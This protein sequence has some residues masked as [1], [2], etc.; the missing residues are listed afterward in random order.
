MHSVKIEDEK[1]ALLFIDLDD[2]K[3]VND[4]AG[5]ETGDRVLTLVAE[6]LTTSVRSRDSVA[7][8]G[9]DEFA[10]ILNNCDKQ[11]ARIIAENLEAL[12]RAVEVDS[13]AGEMR[14]GV[15]I[16][17]SEIGPEGA[18]G[19]DEVIRLA[20]D[21]CYAAKRAGGGVSVYEGEKR[22]ATDG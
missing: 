17:V 2:F 15:S 6:A 10:I 21:A 14:V 1:S 11:Q 18:V 20:D 16:G 13:V 12:V 4:T 7:R 22:A 8:L 5:H 3:S 19:V 9:G